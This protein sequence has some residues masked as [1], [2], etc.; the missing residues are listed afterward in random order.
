MSD[1]FKIYGA[2]ESQFNSQSVLEIAKYVIGINETAMSADK[3]ITVAGVKALLSA[4]IYDL[5]LIKPDYK[6]LDKSIS[7]LKVLSED[8]N[9]RH[10]VSTPKLLAS[11]YSKPV[12]TEAMSLL[13]S[14]N[15]LS[16]TD[17]TA[18]STFINGI[19]NKGEKK[20][21]AVFK[22][23][24]LAKKIQMPQSQKYITRASY[25]YNG[26]FFREVGWGLVSHV[27]KIFFLFYRTFFLFLSLFRYS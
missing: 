17:K 18:L 15:K 11:E 20:D 24:L 3:S 9:F 7:E 12:P 2:T 19:L 22:K 10:L 14:I 5:K 16:G 26:M 6:Y 13:D 1:M 21:S 27:T 4:T 8:K 25:E 23:I